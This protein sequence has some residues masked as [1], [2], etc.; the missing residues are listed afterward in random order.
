MTDIIIP[1][2]VTGLFALLGA[3]AGAAL[4]RRTEYEKWLRQERTQ[5]FATLLKEIHETR[6]YATT[7]YYDESGSEMQRSMKVTESFAKLEKNVNVARLF[8][9][10]SGRVALSKHI[11]GLWLNCS[12]DGGPANRVCK[13]NDLMANI[14][15]TL[16]LEL[17][18]IAWKVRWPFK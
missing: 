13:I 3:F 7:A 1:T 16:E 5:A 11:K 8:M 18:Y 17:N 10:E 2:L 14:Q 4:T 15:A 9:S 6:L 12:T